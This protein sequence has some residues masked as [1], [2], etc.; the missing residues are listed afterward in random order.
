MYLPPKQPSYHMIG[1]QPTLYLVCHLTM[2]LSKQ[3]GEDQINKKL[4]QSIF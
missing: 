3:L 1:M 4:I 2:Q